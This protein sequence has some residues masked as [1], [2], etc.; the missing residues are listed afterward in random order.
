MHRPSELYKCKSS[1]CCLSLS[2]HLQGLPYS[3]QYLAFMTHI[4]SFFFFPSCSWKSINMLKDYCGEG[5]SMSMTCTFI[6]PKPCYCTYKWFNHFVVAL[7]F[8][9]Q[10]WEM[11]HEQTWAPGTTH[12]YCQQFTIM[13]QAGLYLKTPHQWPGSLTLQ[14][15]HILCLGYP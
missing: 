2:K 8:S 3:S 4:K 12:R 6:W 7:A 1:Y 11:L 13:K 9:S 5:S 14:W 15:L 10:H